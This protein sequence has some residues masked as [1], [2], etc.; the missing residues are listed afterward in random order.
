MKD[1]SAY[2]KDLWLLLAPTFDSA[3]AIDGLGGHPHKAQAYA[4]FIA[5]ACG[6][7]FAELG[8]ESTM[9]VLAAI[10]QQIENRRPA[11]QTTH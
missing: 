8:Y 10:A 6:S 1:A 9:A 4:G 3:T 2:G 11:P 7:M 5:A